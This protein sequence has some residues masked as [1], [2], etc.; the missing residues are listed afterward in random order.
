MVQKAR[1]ASEINAVDPNNHLE[2]L[3]GDWR[4]ERLSGL[5]PPMPGVWKRIH[6]CR[7]ETRV[8][9]LPGIPFDLEPRA[10]WVALI[11]RSPLSMVTDRLTPEADGSWMGRAT[12]KGI[13]LGR[14]SMR[15]R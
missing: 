8:G 5:L 13:E 4:V 12:I 10:D 7:G 9:P 1:P 15:R 11:Y 3:Q 2:K 14:F 6:G